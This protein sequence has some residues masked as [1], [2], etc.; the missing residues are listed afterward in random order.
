MFMEFDRSVVRQRNEELRHEARRWD[1][2]GRLR[3]GRKESLVTR[4]QVDN[5][6]TGTGVIHMKALAL[7]LLG[8]RRNPYG[9]TPR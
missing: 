4:P 6:T 8:L 7:N 9:S 2:Q 3:A 1:L 5:T